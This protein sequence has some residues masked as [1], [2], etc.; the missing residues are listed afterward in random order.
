MTPEEIQQAR[1]VAQG[2]R[3]VLS[4]NPSGDEVDALAGVVL[5][6]T[7]Q[8]PEPVSQVTLAGELRRLTKSDFGTGAINPDTAAAVLLS[9][10]TITARPAAGLAEHGRRSQHLDRWLTELFPRR[11]LAVQLGAPLCDR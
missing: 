6:L 5:A 2:M 8:Q 1:N 11:P 3:N 9:R 10:F 4:Y 7:E